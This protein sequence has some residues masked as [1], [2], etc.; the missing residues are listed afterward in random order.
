MCWIALDRAVRLA[1][2]IGRADRRG[3]WAATRD[4][5]RATILDHGWNDR[6]G[7][8]TQTLDGDTLDAS[9]LLL[10][11]TGFLPVDDPRMQAT[12][13]RVASDLSAPCGLLYRY[14]GKA[15]LAEDEGVFIVCSFWLVQCL[16]AS[17]DAARA[18]E[19]FERATAYTNDLGLLSE[20]ADPATGELM[21]NFPHGPTHV[22]LI[23]AAR[24]LSAA[25][26]VVDTP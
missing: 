17:G 21:G 4:E 18:V 5:V 25:T 20:E 6:V 3:D 10:A 26:E 23:N 15:G 13:E 1:E 9:V 2:R 22:G 14:A 16:A 7:A 11:L 12:I 24:S 8:F 19:L